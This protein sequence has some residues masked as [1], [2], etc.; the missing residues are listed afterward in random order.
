MSIALILAGHG[1]HIS[2]NTAGVVWGYV[3]RLRQWGVADEITACFWKEVPAFSHVLD[4]VV[5]DTVVIV[6]VFTAQG[7][8]TQTVIPTE[9]GFAKEIGKSGTFSPLP[10]TPSPR[11]NE[12]ASSLHLHSGERFRGGISTN[13]IVFQRGDK[14]IYYTPTIG[15]HPYLETIVQERVT[16]ALSDARL[17][18]DETAVAIIGHGTRRNSQSRDATRHQA[19]RIR[20]HGFVAEVI[21][22][23]LDDDP[24]I[25]SLYKST[26]AQN[27]IAIPFFLAEGSHVAI[28]VPDAL[29]IT[30]G[31]YPAAVNGRD[32]YY[33]PPVGTDDA[34]CRVILELARDTG[35]SFDENNIVGKRHVNKKT[36]WTGFPKAGQDAFVHALESNENLVLG[37]VMVTGDKVWHTNE[38]GNT[39]AR[40]SPEALRGFLRETPFR[41]LPT[42]DDL[43]LGWHVDVNSPHEAYAVVETIYPTLITDWANQQNNSFITESLEDIGTRQTGMFENIHVLDVDVINAT[44][45][46][47]CGRCIRQP[48][49]LNGHDS[50]NADLPCK[51]P[52]NLWLSTL[53]LKGETQ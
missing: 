35:V 40:P 50:D 36:A 2:P 4:T 31:D 39:S 38:A 23:Y 18:P 28:D 30:F 24:D 11:C 42:S 37:Q 5:S 32:V 25:A 26:S 53:K 41:P 43:P 13:N 20:E 49:W 15:E 47:V 6:P 34:M 27:V 44:V 45:E 33:T 10:Q 7:Y 9:M 8:F 46:V 1:S 48:S 16:C 22:V 29:G 3:D 52:C 21:D 12:G 51:T 14:T 19:N 17:N